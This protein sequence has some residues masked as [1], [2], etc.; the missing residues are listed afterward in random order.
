LRRRESAQ[1]SGDVP[2]QEIGPEMSNDEN[3]GRDDDGKATLR[4]KRTASVKA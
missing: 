2:E 3:E 4:T 1:P